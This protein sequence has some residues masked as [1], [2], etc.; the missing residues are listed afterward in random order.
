MVAVAEPRPAKPCW[1]LSPA[2]ITSYCCRWEHPR[3]CLESR[4]APTTAAS[5]APW[6][7]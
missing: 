5:N 7:A 2:G 1:E 6:C 3:R 4:S